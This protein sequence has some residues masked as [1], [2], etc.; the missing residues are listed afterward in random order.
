MLEEI[1]LGAEPEIPQEKVC[2][3]CIECNKILDS[4]DLGLKNH[5]EHT[6]NLMKVPR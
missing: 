6:L 2:F 4:D 1:D 3:K 5:K